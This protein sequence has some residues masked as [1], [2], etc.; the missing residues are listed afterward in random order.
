MWTCVG[1]PA[2]SEPGLCSLRVCRARGFLRSGCC[3]VVLFRLGCRRFAAGSCNRSFRGDC[4][5]HIPSRGTAHDNRE[6][7]RRG[8][9]LGR[10]GFV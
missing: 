6:Q 7:L 10:R 2:S 9:G 5:Q 4:S 3:L 8:L 1:G